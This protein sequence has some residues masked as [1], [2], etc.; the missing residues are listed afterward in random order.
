MNISALPTIEKSDLY[1]QPNKCNHYNQCN[2]QKERIII[3]KRLNNVPSCSKYYKDSIFNNYK[4]N[5]YPIRVS[6]HYKRESN[7]ETNCEQRGSSILNLYKM[8]ED[9]S[10]YLENIL[11]GYR[12]NSEL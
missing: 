11:K 12:V 6:P 1:T 7:N 9:N 4:S 5:A 8:K 3:P 10:V 2:I